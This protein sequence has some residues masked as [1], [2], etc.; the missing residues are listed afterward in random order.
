MS[1]QNSSYKQIVKSTGIFGG[2]QVVNIIIGFVR[3]KIVALLLGKAGIGLIGNYQSVVDMVRSVSGLGFDVSGMREVSAAAASN[4]RRKLEQAVSI[5]RWWIQGTAMLGALVCLVFC[6][7]ISINTF[8]T[9]SY[10]IPV[11]LLSICVFFSTLSVGNTMVI[12]GMRQITSLVKVN[13]YANFGALVVSIP[14]YFWLGMKGLVLSLILGSLVTFLFSYHYF[15]KLK[16]NTI[17]IPAKIALKEGKKTLQ[18]GTY[19]VLATIANASTMYLIRASITSDL[20]LDAAG[21]FQAVWTITGI[22]LGLILRSMGTDFYPRLCAIAGKNAGVRKL[23]NEQTYIVLII[24]SPMIIAMILLAK[25]ALSVLYSSDFQAANTLLQWQVLGSFLKV[26]SWPMGFIILAK[27][28]GP[29]YLISEVLF[30]VVYLLSAHLLFPTMGIDA[31]GLGYLIAYGV[32]LV[33]MF[34]VSARLCRFRWR[35]DVV[36]MMFFNT[37]L[38]VA[39]FVCMQKIES[40]WAYA[41]CGAI[42]LFSVIYSLVKLNK[43]VDIRSFLKKK[44]E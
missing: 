32:Y 44:K 9:G 14:I 31:A 34:V 25:V 6:Y 42:L 7:P 13:V 2:S 33:W 5:L 17:K 28:K 30:F 20:G 11:A 16:L 29:F 43:T 35:R 37:L 38:I 41:V 15:R 18:L 10:A 1:K 22:Y 39:T 36:A 4:D 19:I 40:F 8:E 21:L 24:A 23:V 12:Q 26:L 27:G 3:N